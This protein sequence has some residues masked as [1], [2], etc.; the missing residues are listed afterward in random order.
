MWHEERCDGGSGEEESRAEQSRAEESERK[1]GR[2]EN[3]RSEEEAR[4]RVFNREPYN[5]IGKRAGKGRK[6]QE[7]TK[8]GKS[9]Q[10]EKR[11]AEGRR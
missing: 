2:E 11:T 4:T 3:A 8:K 9:H 5:Q 10:T 1:R 6:A 7:Q